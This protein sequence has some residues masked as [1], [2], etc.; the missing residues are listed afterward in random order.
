M[1]AN[2]LKISSLDFDQI[3]S[4]IIAYLSADPAFTDYNFAGSGLNTLIDLLVSNT[5]YQAF[6]ANMM[7]N[8]GFLNTMVKRSSVASRAAEL[9]YTPK[10]A[11]GA[12]ATVDIQV[13][14]GSNPPPA[15]VYLPAATAFGSSGL[16]QASG[17]TFYNSTSMVATADING[18]YWFRN[19]IIKEGSPNR[20]RFLVDTSNPDQAFI[21]PNVRTDTTT[22]KVSVQKSAT[23]TTQTTFNLANNYT[24]VTGTD[25]VYFLEEVD[26]EKFRIYFGD[27]N[28][29]LPVV[30]GNIIICEY[31]VCGSTGANGISKFS[32]GASLS[33]TDSGNSFR[34]RV[35]TVAAAAGGSDIES[36]DSIRF[37]APKAWTAQN[38]LVTKDDYEH[39]ILNIVPNIESVSVWGGEN[40]IPPQY[41]KVFISLKPLSGFTFSDVAKA[42]IAANFINNKSLVSIIP[43]FIDP[44]YIHVG[45]ETSVKYNAQITNKT[46]NAVATVVAAAIQSFFNNEMEKFGKNFY[47]S[48]L[49]NAIDNSDPSIVGSLT[50]VTLQKR[51]V[52]SL[53]RTI[54]YTVTFA[55]NKI[56]PSKLSTSWFS[57]V[58]NGHQ[59][60]KVQF[61]D[62]PDQ[63]NFSSSY[64]G[65]G[66]L[67][68]R[69]SSGNL[70]LAN[71]GTIDYA[72]GIIT[73]SPLE[74]IAVE[75]NDG[76]IRFTVYLQEDS[77]DVVTV[78][79][80]IIVLDDTVA[81][82]LAGMNVNGLVVTAGAA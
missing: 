6:Y 36:I 80:N 72:T 39:Y 60:D 49:V 12:E 64:N 28:I 23:D 40:N 31:M 50:S 3:K 48:Q 69:D 30:N 70:I 7:V 33:A 58:I 21:L 17:Y 73:V 35:D 62:L 46:D 9:G 61:T 20:T 56:H 74:L 15:G 38:R 44:E 8:E 63:L 71:V 24:S 11:V 22:L 65:S 2:N 26:G 82:P 79:N 16:N 14:L 29:G 25:P 27:G 5:H 47:F 77:L 68:L 66:A 37:Y 19:V 52:P 78:R 54:G 32:I 34:T 76:T 45:V 55:P 59:Y 43:T 13:L 57:C 81:D 42:N 18:Q 53:F 10:S 67:Q 41:G 51:L 75:A 4:S 1:A